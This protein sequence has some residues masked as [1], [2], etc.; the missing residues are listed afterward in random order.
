M[1]SHY[2]S[3]SFAPNG[4]EEEIG[5]LI[6]NDYSYDIRISESIDAAEGLYLVG[7]KFGRLIT[8]HQTS[9][10]KLPICSQRFLKARRNSG[11]STV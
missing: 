6:D 1:Y 4:N 3:F 7:C 11:R 8:G 9:T 10:P 5:I 2:S